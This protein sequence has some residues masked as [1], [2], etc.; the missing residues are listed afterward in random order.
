MMMMMMMMM[1]MTMTMM[2]IAHLICILRSLMLSTAAFT[3]LGTT[4]PRYIR[5]HAKYLPRRV[6]HLAKQLEGSKTASWS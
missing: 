1:M 6:W 4:S 2:M 5:K 3:S